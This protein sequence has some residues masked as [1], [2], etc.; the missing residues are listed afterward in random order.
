MITGAYKAGIM[1]K[2]E[3]NCKHPCKLSIAFYSM[4]NV[5]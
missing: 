1:G 5:A 3:K 2:K 4:N